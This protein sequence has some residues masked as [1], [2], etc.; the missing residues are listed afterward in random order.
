MNSFA[1]LDIGS[2]TVRLLIA[3]PDETG[4]PVPLCTRT[5]I[6]RLAGGFD[7]AT[8]RLAPESLERTMA[9]LSDYGQLIK[10]HE[11]SVVRAAATGICRKAVNANDLLKT[12]FE[13]TGLT[14]EVISGE[15][16]ADLALDGAQLLLGERQTPFVFLDIGGSSTELSYCGPDQRILQSLDLGVVDLTERLV[17]NDPPSNQ[18]LTDLF[19]AIDPLL[20]AG[21]ERLKEE[22]ADL[23]A[24]LAGA[25]GT[26]TTAAAM[27]LKLEPYDGARVEK[28]FLTGPETADLLACCA[29][30]TNGERRNLPGLSPGREDVII[31]GLVVIL[32][33]IERSGCEG[34][35]V[36]E[37]SLLE[38]LW[39]T[40]AGL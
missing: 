1:A 33:A 12:V 16:E 14:I 8:G 38:G 29:L 24:R 21:F 15:R 23:P 39:L 13:R 25:A 4:G 7:R 27:R 18:D 40:A 6:T 2:N 10:K 22:G 35:L 26:V 17:K 31:A 3:R 37:G 34:L 9:V 28:Y 20:K 36:T 5:R 32:S 30:M 19:L 11:V